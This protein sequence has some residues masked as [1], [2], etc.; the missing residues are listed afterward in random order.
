M[1]SSYTANLAAFLTAAKMEGAINSAEDLAKQTKVKYG[2]YCCGSTNAFF[3]VCEFILRYITVNLPQVV[4]FQGST[5]PT[6]QK[7][8]A[9]MESAKPSVYTDGNNEGIERVMKEDGGYAFFMEAASMEYH[10][11]RN[12]ELTQIGDKLD[13]KGY[14]VALPPGKKNRFKYYFYYYFYFCEIPGS[15]YTKAI[16]D[17]ILELQEKGTLAVLYN[18]WWKEKG[19]GG[20]CQVLTCFQ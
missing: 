19:G 4:V 9:F 2:T 12:C 20:N 3:Q 10:M 17:G 15:P 16:S 7:L 13:S 5:L 1:I 6:I 18:R 11:E 14:G 8:N